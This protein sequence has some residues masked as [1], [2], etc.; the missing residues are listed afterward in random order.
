MGRGRQEIGLIKK[1]TKKL[2]NAAALQVSHLYPI[3]NQ[4]E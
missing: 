3:A 1:I 2:H 4:L